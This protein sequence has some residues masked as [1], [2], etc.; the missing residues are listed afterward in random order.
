MDWLGS[1]LAGRSARQTQV[2]ERWAEKMRPAGGK[3]QC[4]TN[5]RLTSPLFA[6]MVN[7]AAWHVVEQDDV[8]NGSVVHPGATVIPAALAAVQDVGVSGKAFT[9]LIVSGYDTVIRVGRYLGQSHYKIFHTTGTAGTRDATI[10]A[11]KLLGLTADQL[12]HTLWSEGLWEF[13]HDA[14]D[15]KQLHTAKAGADGLLSAY[16]AR[17]ESLGA[18]QIF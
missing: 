8:H 2:L 6:A 14:A 16:A 1:V 17:W 13:L 10:A 9:L 18:R 11:G 4:L 12:R 7:G 15:S 5:G 3:A